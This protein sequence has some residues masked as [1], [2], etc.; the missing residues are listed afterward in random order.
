MRT[1]KIFTDGGSRGNPGPAAAAF[2]V[3]EGDLK[4]KEGKKY[5]GVNTNN[6]AEYQALLMAFN[7]LSS[8]FDRNEKEKCSFEFYLDSQLVV[9]QLKGLY[10]IKSTSLRP[11]AI[12]IKKMER[13]YEML[14]FIHVKRELNKEA[15]ALVNNVLDSISA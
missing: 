10:K 8:L 9:N 1:I 15:D 4:I 14:K 5:L 12:K 11:L 2:V 3:Y 6:F 13:E 7:E